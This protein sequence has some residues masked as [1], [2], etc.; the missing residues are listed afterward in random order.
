MG[1][2]PAMSTLS[3]AELWA[4]GRALT[5]R[6]AATT[7]PVAAAFVFLP[8][9][10]QT[11][12][13]GGV[14]PGSAPGGIQGTLSLMVLLAAFV[15]QVAIAAIMLG[16]RFAPYDVRD[17]LVRA[18]R[19]LPRML[20]VLLLVVL[21]ALPLLLIVGTLLVA[22]VGPANAGN[23][24]AVMQA[25]SG[26][27]LPLFLLFVY[28]SARL[29]LLFPVLAAEGLPAGA[30]LRR[31]WRLTALRRWPLFGFALS[32]LV[33][34]LFLTLVVNM[35]AGAVL[36]LLLG[37]KSTITMLLTTTLAAAVGT[38]IGLIGT[39]ASVAAYH[40]LAGE[41]R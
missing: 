25:A 35:V 26:L 34:G 6:H 18:V 19:L 41:Q 22:T 21:V 12:L 16:G 17:A 8:Q 39:G 40:A 13:G 2:N 10:L 30:S 32:A 7:I 24:Q 20:L 31:T 23:V 11:V 28:V 14:Q 33:A 27:V 38:A 4:Q 5:E 29:F 3:V 37:A 9:V 1:Q 15:G 36:G